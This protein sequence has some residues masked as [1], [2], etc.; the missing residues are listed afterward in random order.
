VRIKVLPLVLL[1][2]VV[3][4]T[5]PSF[6]DTIQTLTVGGI[7]FTA[8][9][10]ANTLTHS[11][12]LVF[13]GSNTLTTAATLNAFAL[14][15]FGDGSQADFTLVTS[16]SLSNWAFQDGAKINNSGPGCPTSSPGTAGW[17]CGTADSTVHALTLAGNGSFSWVF[18]GTFANS[19]IP[20]TQLELMANGLTN[21]KKW[22]TSSPMTDAPPPSAVPEPASL[23]LFGT[24]IMAIAP[25]VRRRR[26]HS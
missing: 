9:L 21:G 13:S 2:L 22:A 3:G 6:G 24:S 15:I 16:P 12:T 19:A 11:Y 17:F 26:A 23:V 8:D 10:N 1:S 25:F 4:V 14:Q 20:M 5:L 18:T 7:D